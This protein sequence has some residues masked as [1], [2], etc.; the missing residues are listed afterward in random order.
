M[1]GANP[2]LDSEWSLLVTACSVLP[3]NEKLD[4]IRLQLREPIDWK[5][6]CDLADRHGTQPLLCQALVAAGRSLPADIMR[7]LQQDYQ[8]NLHKA[9]LLSR[10][11]IR[12][13]ERLSALSIEFLPYKGLAL[14][15][16]IYGD[17]A[18]RQPGDIDLLIHPE[19]LPL[20]RDAVRDLG[21]TPHQSFSG[22]EERA[23]LRSGYECPF[24]GTAG[25]NL[26]EVQWA[27][28]PRFYAI[29]F[30]MNGFFERAVQITVAGRAMKTLSV[31]DLFLVL[32]AHAAKHVWGRL[33]WLSDIARIMNL[34]N[35][36]WDWIGS[37][38]RQLGI[39]RILR[40]TMLLASRLLGASIPPAAQASIPEDPVS[41][42]FAQKTQGHLAY[43]TTYKVESLS[44]FRLMMSL[45]ERPGDRFRFLE[46]LAFTPGPSEW[47]AIRLPGY[48]FPLY[49]LVRLSRLAAR[50]VRI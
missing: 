39:A 11:L 15:E 7:S 49:R 31:E 4:R 16:F 20:I 25:R 50:L 17:I 6:L 45:R 19:D 33:V 32:S 40:V 26:L 34:P 37:Q 24:D 22:A 46:R 9:L 27:I 30:E 43:E 47:Q 48:L 36:N 1:P 18:L 14:A 10:E 42:T 12:I 44:Y 28:Q 3:S 13:A 5:I 38:A 21:Y 35:L 8:T 29:D 2:A 23:H 41:L